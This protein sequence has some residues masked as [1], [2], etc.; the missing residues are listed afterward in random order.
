MNGLNDEPDY[1]M[2][3]RK[4]SAQIR[5]LWTAPSKAVSARGA[6]H[7]GKSSRRSS[8]MGLLI[9]SVLL[10]CVSGCAM[11]EWLRGGGLDGPNANLGSGLRSNTGNGPWGTGIDERAREIERNLGYRN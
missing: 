8:L 2:F 7:R 3:P 11:P 1:V 10:G 6:I 4:R 9:L 5:P